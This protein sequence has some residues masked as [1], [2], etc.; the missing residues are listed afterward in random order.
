MI[1]KYDKKV[2]LNNASIKFEKGKIYGI[3]GESGMESQHFNILLGL[4][5]AEKIKLQYNQIDY[6]TE[7]QFISLTKKLVLSLKVKQF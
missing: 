1:F 7:K 2:V 5:K 4:I 3:F 6:E